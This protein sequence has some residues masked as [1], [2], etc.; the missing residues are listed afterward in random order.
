MC[1]HLCRKKS[2]V[3]QYFSSDLYHQDL[4]GSLTINDSGSTAAVT[5]G[6]CKDF[7]EFR[8]VI[9]KFITI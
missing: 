8:E 7:F 1:T 3:Y 5:G 2:F 4:D 6:T 9:T